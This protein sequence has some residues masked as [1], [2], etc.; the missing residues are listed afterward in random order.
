MARTHFT[1]NGQIACNRAQGVTSENHTDVDCKSCMNTA[2]YA[3]VKANAEWAA[4]QA[5]TVTE[6]AETVTEQAET[7]TEVATEQ[8]ETVPA[9]WAWEPLWTAVDILRRRAA[10]RDRTPLWELI[11]NRVD[12]RVTGED[13][14]RPRVAPY[15]TIL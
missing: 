7:V 1:S 4:A 3:T 14:P 10:R 5:E 9:P 13:V 6:Q 8:A 15:A 12:L 2:L 11:R